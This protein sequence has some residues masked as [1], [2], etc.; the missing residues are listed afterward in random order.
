MIPPI[1]DGDPDPTT[2]T[3]WPAARNRQVD[4]NEGISNLNVHRTDR[5]LVD[6]HAKKSV[7]AIH[8]KPR[9]TTWNLITLS[10]SMAGAQVAWTVELG[11]EY[12]LNCKIVTLTLIMSCKLRN[13]VF[14]WL[15]SFR[16]THI[17]RMAGGS[18]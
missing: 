2:Q 8:G 4:T 6:E 16:R 12:P 7:Q 9:L 10:V 5:I 14:T 17:S 18:N 3:P 15:R 1:S 13:A 11:Y